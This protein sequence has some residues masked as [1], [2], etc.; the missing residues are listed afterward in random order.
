ML[1]SIYFGTCLLQL[2]SEDTDPFFLAITVFPP[3]RWPK[4]FQKKL[5]QMTFYLVHKG[6]GRHKGQSSDR[7]IE[8]KILEILERFS[9]SCICQ[10]L[11]PSLGITTYSPSP[12][13]GI[14]ICSS[15]STLL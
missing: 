15:S 4:A 6:R 1:L 9:S 10:L 5:A 13:L 2:S 3:H 11:S 12:S 7:G 14:T 8:G